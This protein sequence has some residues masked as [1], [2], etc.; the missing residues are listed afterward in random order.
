MKLLS[1][2]SA[3]AEKQPLDEPVYPAVLGIYE[4]TFTVLV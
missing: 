4:M 3:V 2:D 1:K